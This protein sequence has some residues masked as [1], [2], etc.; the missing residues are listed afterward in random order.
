[1]TAPGREVALVG[2]GYSE[3]HRSGGPSKE[4]L[5]VQATR[6]ALNDAGIAATDV[7]GLFTYRFPDGSDAPPAHW[8]M[9]AL[10]TRDISVWMELY[11]AAPSGVAPVLAAIQSVA[12]G[13]CDMALVYRC[14]TTAAGR[15][16]AGLPLPLEEYVPAPGPMQ[17]GAPFGV[18]NRGGGIADAAFRMRRRMTDYG[19]KRED[20]G[21]IALNA[22]RWS[23]NNDR[24]L[25]RTPLT[26]ED[27]LNVR[28]IM[29]PFCLFD[30]DYPVSGC[31]ALVVTTAERARDTK[32]QPVYVD[33]WAYGTEIPAAP[34][35]E[36]I[37]FGGMASCAKRLWAK[38]SF[39]VEDMD[40]AEL[41]DGYSFITL[42]WVEALGFCGYG[43]FP[44]W[45]DNGK[46]IGPG[47]RVPLNTHGGMST[48]GRLHG[49][50]FVTEAVLQL[51][52]QCGVRQ[53]PEA[54]TAV[55]GSA[56]NILSGA[57]VLR[58]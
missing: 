9:H 23:V 19:A 49:L 6:N 39:V 1:M 45:V 43:E 7:D 21:Q 36:R 8:V 44:D 38:S 53:V 25:L 56:Y 4:R 12:S 24:A 15:A 46:T 30:S 33:S 27:Y 40:V 14:M 2:V 13:T 29:D 41:Y 48:E 17:W 31:T 58:N 57:I 54:R 10:G 37:Q 22:R 26:M 55:I 28:M 34:E 20:W 42:S 51:R 47:G 5:T 50:P 11:Q 35:R 52:G 18:G 16:G 32:Q 3:I